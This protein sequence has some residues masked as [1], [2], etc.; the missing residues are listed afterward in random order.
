MPLQRRVPKF[1]FKN[2]NRVEYKAINLDTIRNLLKLRAWQ[3]LVLTTLL[4]QDLFLQI[5]WLK[6]LGNGTLTNK[7]EVEAH[8][9]SK[10]ATAAI[11][12]AGGTV[13][14]L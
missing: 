13:V 7:L 9:F 5:S 8:A 10:T 1:G 4:K 6:V 3:K 11:E 14:K 12:A 2:I